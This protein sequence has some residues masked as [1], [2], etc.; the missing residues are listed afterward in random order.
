MPRVRCQLVRCLRVRR[1][2]VRR[3]RVRRLLLHLRVRV[4]RRGSVWPLC[5]GLRTLLRSRGRNRSRM[6][7][8]TNRR[9]RRCKYPC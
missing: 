6:V 1:L 3:L 9:P 5:S 8:L 2:R 7:Y 4:R